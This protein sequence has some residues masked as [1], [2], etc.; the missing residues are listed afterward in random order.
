MQAAQSLPVRAAVFA[1]RKHEGQKRNNFNRDP[2]TSHLVEVADLVDHAGG[3]DTEIAGAWG[4]DLLEDT[5]ATYSEVKEELGK[6]VADLVAEVTDPPS[7]AN[8]PTLEHKLLQAKRIAKKS[9]SAKRIKIA[10]Q[11]ANVRSMGNDVPTR[12]N[13]QNNLDYLRG[14]KQIVDVCKSASPQLASEFQKVY[15]RTLRV[16]ASHEAAST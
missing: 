14:A 11:I 8:L 16:F 1:I 13:R 12:K 5:D 9:R 10:D 7:F 2:Y 3:S 6:E 15:I 4:H